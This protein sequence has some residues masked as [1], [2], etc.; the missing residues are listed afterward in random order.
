[1]AETT[2]QPNRFVFQQITDA[3][4][5]P[6]EET[7]HRAQ[8]YCQAAFAHVRQNFN[9]VLTRCRGGE[10]GPEVKRAIEDNVDEWT[11][12]EALKEATGTCLH[13]SG[14]DQ[15]GPKAPVWLIRFLF[16]CLKESDELGPEPTSLKIVEKRGSLAPEEM[17]Q[18][19]N[20]SIC[21][22]FGIGTETGA[23]AVLATQMRMSR[24]FFGELLLIALTQPDEALEAHLEMY[25]DFV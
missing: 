22:L 1:M 21:M 13:L 2:Q 25:E 20:S 24:G 3:A 16:D 17:L 4:K 15:G 10:F 14:W 12:R 9:Y 5:P 23:A 7:H 19:L 18:D 8:F 6:D 11:F